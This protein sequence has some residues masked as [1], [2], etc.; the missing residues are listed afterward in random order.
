MRVSISGSHSTG[1]STLAEMCYNT[2]HRMYPGN[3]AIIREVA[4]EVAKEGY[5]IVKSVTHDSYYRGI[6]K[7]LN[8]ERMTCGK[9]IIC[10]RSMIDYL[11]YLKVNCNSNLFIQMV[12][13]IVWLESKYFDRYIFLPIEFN[14]IDDS[15]RDTD[16]VNR[17]AIE[18]EIIAL[19][20]YFNIKAI[21]VSGN[22]QERLNTL[23]SLF[24]V[25][26]CALDSSSLS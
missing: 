8:Y 18:D 21:K 5:P 9:F 19:F 24:N 20:K 15:V 4:R 16:E 7:Q 26:G 22:F 2:L 25:P 1:K 17:K 13:E 23:M 3:V 6:F 10:D 12:E 11:A 14:V